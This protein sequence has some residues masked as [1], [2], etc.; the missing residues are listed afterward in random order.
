QVWDKANVSACEKAIQAANLGVST[1]V[2]GSQIR[3]ILPPLSQERRDQIF[4]LIKKK[5]EDTKIRLRRL[6]DDVLKEMKELFEQKKISEDDKYRGKE[7]IDK[8]ME[9]FNN[10]IEEIIEAKRR[11]IYE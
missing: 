10:K 6:R 9:G 8:A 4:Q 3:V 5:A 2:E 1:I 11:E 7:E